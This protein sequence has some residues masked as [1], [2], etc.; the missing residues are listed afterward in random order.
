M[1]EKELINKMSNIEHKIFKKKWISLPL[2][3]F[4]GCLSEMSKIIPKI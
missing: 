1:S 4:E 2:P 3:Y